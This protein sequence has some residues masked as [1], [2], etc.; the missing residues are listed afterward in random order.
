LAWIWL[1]LPAGVAG[2]VSVL[3]AHKIS[4]IPGVGQCN[5]PSSAQYK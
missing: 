2:C 4:R 3:N 1:G 5:C